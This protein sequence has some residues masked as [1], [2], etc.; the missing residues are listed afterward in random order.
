MGHLNRCC[1][2]DV[3]VALT[4]IDVS[5]ADEGQGTVHRLVQFNGPVVLLNRIPSSQWQ[6][7]RSITLHASFPHCSAGKCSLGDQ[8]K[9]GGFYTRT[10]V[11]EFRLPFVCS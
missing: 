2:L 4:A 6:T 1:D 8:G 9:K 7:Q 5:A 11:T 10:P 3:S